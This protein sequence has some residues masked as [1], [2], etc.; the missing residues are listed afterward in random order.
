MELVHGRH[1]GRCQA[2]LQGG[3]RRCGVACAVAHTGLHAVVVAVGQRHD[4]TARHLHTPA[5]VGLYRGAVALVV[6]RHAQH[7]ARLG[8]LGTAAECPAGDRIDGG[9]L[10]QVQDVVRIVAVARPIG[11]EADTHLRRG[12]VDAHAATGCQRGVARHIAHTG[13]DGAAVGVGGH[14]RGGKQGLPASI[15]AH[16]GGLGVIPP[17]HRHHLPGLGRAA[18]RHQHPGGFFGSVDHVVVGHRVDRQRGQRGVQHKFEHLGRAHIAR[19][20]GLAHF[21]PVVAVLGRHAVSAPG[22]GCPTV[23]LHPVFHGRA[24]LGVGRRLQAR[25][26]GHAVVDQG[27]AVEQQGRIGRGRCAGVD[28]EA[29]IGGKCTVGQQRVAANGQIADGAAAQLQ[30]IGQHQHPIAVAQPSRH[31]PAKAQLGRT[32]A[33]RVLRQHRC[34]GIGLPHLQHH[35]R[36]AAHGHGLVEVHRHPNGVTG[37]EPAVAY[38]AAAERDSKH[39]GFGQHA[40]GFQEGLLVLRIGRVDAHQGEAVARGEDQDGVAVHHF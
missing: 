40:Q 19:R 21:H 36:A 3:W 14:G 4:C 1:I 10:G 13:A 18:A 5:A 15:A 2:H 25:V 29:G 32:R 30:G 24:R 31:L 38:P 11:Q 39:P 27:A 22:A 33:T 35:D 17:L 23:V 12:G 20:V 26:V 34:L 8:P 6:E 37:I 28:F 16:G 7:L 9:A